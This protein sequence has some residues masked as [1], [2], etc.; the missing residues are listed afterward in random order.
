MADGDDAP[1]VP[2]PSGGSFLTRQVLGL[3]TWAWVLVAAGGGFLIYRYEKNKQNSAQTVT[4]SSTTTAPPANATTTVDLPGG[5]SYQ[6]PPWGLNQILSTAPVD[7]STAAGDTY[8]G[9][10]AGLLNFLQATQTAQTPT[11]T[12]PT[13]GT[14]SSPPS[15]TLPSS[16]SQPQQQPSPGAGAATAGIQVQNPTTARELVAQGLPLADN[17]Q[18][19]A[20]YTTAS[21]QPIANPQAAAS[22]FAAGTPVYWINP[23][24][25]LQE[26]TY[27][28]A[29]VPG[30]R[31][32][33]TAAP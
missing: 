12:T 29:T 7:A 10:A 4:T 9:P 33:Y 14:S 22:D 24:G 2:E 25:E 27:G 11:S 21:L 23:S 3:P 20:Q 13:T 19:T 32:L 5:V 16:T 8:E 28:M 31:T 26:A 15:T 30:D 1:E 6:G 17:P 18:Q